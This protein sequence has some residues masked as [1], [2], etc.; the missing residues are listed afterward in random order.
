MTQ[1]VRKCVYIAEFE[2]GGH[3]KKQNKTKK[4]IKVKECKVLKM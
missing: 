3:Y 2:I 1:A 4:K